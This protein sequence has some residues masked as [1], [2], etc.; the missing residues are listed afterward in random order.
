[1]DDLPA[2]LFDWLERQERSVDAVAGFFAEFAL[3]YR[4]RIFGR[5]EFAFGDGPGAGVFVL[6]ERPARVDQENLSLF[7]RRR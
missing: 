3:R 7:G 5:C 6:P 2:L 1:M 4:K